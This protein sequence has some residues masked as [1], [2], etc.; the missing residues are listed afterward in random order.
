M[1][2]SN[3]Q[4]RLYVPDGRVGDALSRITH[5]GVGAHQDDL[6]FMAFHGILACY[7]HDAEWFGGVTCT[8]GTGSAR[9][10]RYAG[11]S[12]DELGAIRVQE[13][14]AA[15]RLGRFGVMIQLG[16][17]SRAVQ[18]PADPRLKEDLKSI[19]RATRPRVIY[20]HNPADKHAT[21]IG[22][23]VP[24]IQALRELAAEYR[25]ERVYGC[26]GWRGLDWMLD[27][28]KVIHDVSANEPLAQALNGVFASQ[29][30]AGKRYDL[31]TLGRRR[32]NATF[33]DAHRTDAAGMVSLA[34][35]LTPLAHDPS[36]SITD[37]VLA[38]I[39]RLEADVRGQL[40]RR[41]GEP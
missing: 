19:L 32:A 35:D 28:D 27:E 26:E 12:G 31:A 33:L 10:G 11:I 20:T 6:E 9:T 41:L 3:P 40:T 8:N 30:A 4:A 34:M 18:D 13:Q 22:V 7:D 16:H 38:Y 14:E 24:V 25:P 15:A 1:T 36:L 5:L 23:F 39:H 2:F 29:I 17:E 37:Y 21:H